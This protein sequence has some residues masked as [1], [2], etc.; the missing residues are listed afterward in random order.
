MGIQVH[1][2]RYGKISLSLTPAGTA[3]GPG[4]QEQTFTSAGLVGLRTTD[5]I[6]NVT[7][8]SSTNGLAIL[9][10]RVSAA[11]TLAITFGN[12]STGALTSASGTHHIHVFRRERQATD[13]AGAL[14]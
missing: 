6:L 10:A 5:E 8:P 14:G 7:A 2:D 12:F 13:V 9:S 11:D 4:I 1:E 3:A